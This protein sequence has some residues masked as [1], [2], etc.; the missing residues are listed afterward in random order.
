MSD[1]VHTSDKLIGWVILAALVVLVAKAVFAPT[2]TYN[3]YN[4]YQEKKLENAE[5]NSGNTPQTQ[6]SLSPEDKQQ[7]DCLSKNIYY[8][9][10]AESDPGKLAVALVT[11]NRLKDHFAPSVCDV[12]YQKTVYKKRTTFQFSW[13]GEKHDFERREPTSWNRCYEIAHAAYVQQIKK[14]NPIQD[15]TGGA[16]YYYAHMVVKRPR[17]AY[18]HMQTAAIGG[19]WFFR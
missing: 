10:R 15:F 5:P 1:K 11:F 3:T 16:R 4:L 13:V 2:S 14:H 19:H 7:I 9:A 8:E 17:W 12:V 6:P 18:T